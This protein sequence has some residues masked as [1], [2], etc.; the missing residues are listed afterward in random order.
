MQG[1]GQ[2]QFFLRYWRTAPSTQE[3]QLLRISVAWLQAATGASFSVFHD[4][5]TPITY[6][7]SLWHSPNNVPQT[8]REN[9]SFNMDLILA[10]TWFHARE[11]KV[12]NWCRL[13]LQAVFISDLVNVQGTPIDVYMHKGEVG[14]DKSSITL[15][16][17]F[18]QDRPSDWSWT[19]WRK[20]YLLWSTEHGKLRTP[21]G[22]LCHHPT[23]PHR[24]VWPSHY[25]DGTL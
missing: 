15:T 19:L 11:I 8:A 23:G 10:S 17:Q 7:D 18:V 20:A 4:V 13:Y 22:S 9:D 6:S 2:L 5:R 16:H 12:L 25:G 21:L 1:S 14:N 3:G 24:R